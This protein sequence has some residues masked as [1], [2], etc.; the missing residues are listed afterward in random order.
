MKKETEI[1]KEKDSVF[2]LKVLYRQNSSWQGIISTEKGE[3][4]YYRSE[5]ELL[6]ILDGYMDGNDVS[7]HA[8]MNP[9]GA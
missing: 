9:E 6:K 3:S 8:V 4:F 1:N 2:V 5:L 7:A